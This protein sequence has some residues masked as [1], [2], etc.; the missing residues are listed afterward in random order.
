MVHSGFLVLILLLRMLL[1]SFHFMSMCPVQS[2][3]VNKIVMRLSLF[4]AK[5]RVSVFWTSTFEKITK[6]CEGKHLF[7]NHY[8]D[9]HFT[10]LS[11]LQKCFDVRRKISASF[12]KKKSQPSLKNTCFVGQKNNCLFYSGNSLFAAQ[13]LRLRDALEKKKRNEKYG[14]YDEYQQQKIQLN[15]SLS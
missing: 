3:M 10:H 11:F 2:V 14:K 13:V 12:N 6:S 1:F 15:N 5:I 9:T 7:W 4:E 8:P